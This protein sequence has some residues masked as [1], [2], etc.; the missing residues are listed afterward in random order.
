MSAIDTPAAEPAA[1]APTARVWRVEVHPADP[2]DDP[3]GRGVAQALAQTGHQVI[4][5]DISDEILE[6][7]KKEIKGN[8][9]VYNLFADKK[10][11]IS[12]AQILSNITFSTDYELLANADFVVENATEKWEI[13]KPIYHNQCYM[14]QP[15]QH[16]ETRHRH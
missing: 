4:L 15:P 10:L 7:A 14:Y 1:D 5:L 11:S 9:R 13:K 3:V 2:A 12:T 16:D 8:I 6:S